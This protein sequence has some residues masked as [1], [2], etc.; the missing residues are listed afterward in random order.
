MTD[1]RQAL[2]D[3]LAIRRALGFKLQRVGQMLPGFVTY[4]EQ[5]GVLKVNNCVH[6][7]QLG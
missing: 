3:Y 6:P 2:D 4:M 7:R 5:A 1:L